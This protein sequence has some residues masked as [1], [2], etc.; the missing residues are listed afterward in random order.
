MTNLIIAIPSY[1]RPFEIDRLVSCLKKQTNKDFSV[2]ILNDGSNEK[3]D[4]I[5]KKDLFDFDFHYIKTPN[6][7]G[8]PLARNKILNYLEKKCSFDQETFLAFLDDDLVI[9]ED[10]ISQTKKY[11]KKFDGFS[12]N[13]IQTSA[14]T[15]FDF[16]RKKN[17]QGVLTPLIGK[18]IPFFGVYFSGFYIKTKKIKRVDF[19]PGYCMVYNLSKNRSKRFDLNLNEGNFTGEDTCFSLNLKK[20]GNKL[21]YISSYTIKHD[22]AN[23][24]G[25]RIS[26]H[27]KKF[28]WYWKHKL[29]IIKSNCNILFFLSSSFFCFFESIILS[30]IFKKNLTG[31][32][33]K[34][35]KTFYNKND[36]GK[37]IF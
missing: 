35:L 7:S 21:Y 15:L 24:G 11:A 12:F 6:P 33:L 28:F 19:L 14:S 34:A 23:T 31:E 36:S 13:T 2:V 8:L 18:F 10:F 22:P 27:K 32:Y 26:E 25:C 29:Y 9:K 3:Y 37:N 1:N 4:A 5:L 30:I 17:I 20:N 16:T